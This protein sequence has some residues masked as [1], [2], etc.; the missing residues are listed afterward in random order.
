MEEASIADGSMTIH[1]VDPTWPMWEFPKIKALNM[2]QK[3]TQY[4]TKGHLI[5]TKSPSYTDPE[6]RSYIL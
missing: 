4:G 2:D 5:W 1:A 6:N 3:G